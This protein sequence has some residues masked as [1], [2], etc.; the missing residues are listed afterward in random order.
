VV[1]GAE[2][3]WPK[4]E[5]PNDELPKLGLPTGLLVLLA[6]VPMFPVFPLIVF[7]SVSGS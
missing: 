3:G 1:V 5:L 2:G 7:I 4:L 6:G